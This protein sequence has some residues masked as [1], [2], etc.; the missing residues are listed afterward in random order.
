MQWKRYTLDNDV[1]LENSQLE[2]HGVQR[3]RL[4]FSRCSIVFEIQPMSDTNSTNCVPG[5]RQNN[6]FTEGLA[7]LRR[8]VGTTSG[9]R[10]RA[11][12]L[13]LKKRL[14]G[15]RGIDHG[16]SMYSRHLWDDSPN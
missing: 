3:S 4:I 15:I 9:S 16:A 5:A 13:L 12:D 14:R 7:R 1:R 2:Y 10:P 6:G 11:R 8:T